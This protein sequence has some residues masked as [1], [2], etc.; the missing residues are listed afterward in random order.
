MPELT[1]YW[2]RDIPAQVTAS[3]GD[4]SARVQLDERFEKAIDAAAMTAGLTG[5]DEY[6]VEWRRESR[7]CGPDLEQ[8][9]AAEA[10]GL[11][12]AFPPDELRRL[13]RSGGRRTDSA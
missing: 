12:A 9:A 8:E 2:W 1:V 5:S 4:A 3:E 10:A 6:L 11:E 13:A 7:D